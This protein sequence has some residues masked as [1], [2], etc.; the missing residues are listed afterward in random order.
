MENY[1]YITKKKFV[2]GGERERGSEEVYSGH[3]ILL[4]SLF[5][6]FQKIFYEC[7]PTEL[8]F[9]YSIYFYISIVSNSR[10]RDFFQVCI[11]F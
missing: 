11:I 4:R 10:E 3:F 9:L 7:L 6:P 5:F 2:R 8:W 1:G